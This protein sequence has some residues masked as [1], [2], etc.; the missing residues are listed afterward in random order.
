M[1]DTVI[2][3]C[4]YFLIPSAQLWADVSFFFNE[5]NFGAA[6]A[7]F[8]TVPAVCCQNMWLS[9]TCVCHCTVIELFVKEIEL[10]CSNCYVYAL[11]RVGSVRGWVVWNG[12]E[13]EEHAWTYRNMMCAA[14]T[15]TVAC[16]LG[17]CVDCKDIYICRILHFRV[18]NSFKFFLYLF[19][20]LFHW[21]K[22]NEL[23]HWIWH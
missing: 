12:G 3:F 21:R 13:L 14:N 16:N 11:V 7:F 19:T 8:I 23:Q 1:S 20:F 4:A 15:L 6:C 22:W 10:K 18:A 9:V 2:I 5:Y 17:R